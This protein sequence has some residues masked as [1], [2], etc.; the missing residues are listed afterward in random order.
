VGRFAELFGSSF[1]LGLVTRTSAV[2]AW[3]RYGPGLWIA[4]AK[5]LVDCDVVEGALFYDPGCE[6]A[7]FQWLSMNVYRSVTKSTSRHCQRK[8]WDSSDRERCCLWR[9]VDHEEEVSEAVVTTKRDEPAA[10]KLL[11]LIIKKYGS[12]CGLVT[13]KCRAYSA[14]IKEIGATDRLEVGCLNYRRRNCISHFGEES[15][16]ALFSVKTIARSVALCR[17]EPPLPRFRTWSVVR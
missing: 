8:D 13:E 15:D 6:T 9:A 17:G 4:S 3:I 2:V 7:I 10:L 12:P 16:A 5:R 14:A 11:M 1:N